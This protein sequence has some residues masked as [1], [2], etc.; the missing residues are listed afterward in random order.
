MKKIDITIGTGPVGD[1][2]GVACGVR[3][4]PERHLL[5]HN[6]SRK[7]VAVILHGFPDGTEFHTQV[8]LSTWIT[9]VTMAFHVHNFHLCS[10]AILRILFGD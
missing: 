9:A 5:Q 1:G 8:R 3:D 10:R 7:T 6:G 2:E 4:F